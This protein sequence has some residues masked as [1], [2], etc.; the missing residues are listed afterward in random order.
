VA[1]LEADPTIGAASAKVVF[2]ERFAEVE[3]ASPTFVPGTADHRQLGVMV[4]GA[5]VDG[6]DRWRDT[7][8]GAGSWGI[9]HDRSG[10]T[11][12]WTQARAVVRVPVPDGASRPDEVQLRLAAEAPKSVT[13]G[14]GSDAVTVAVGTDP[15]WLTV[16]V[17]GE[18]R[19]VVNN[20]GSVVFDDGYGADRGYLE[21]DEGQFDEGADV[22]AWCGAS[23]LF[24]PVYLEDAGLFDE[25]F[26]LYYED[27]D[28][29]WRGLARGWRHR[30]VPEAVVR[31]VHAAS[32]GEG[33][34][35]FQHFVERNRLLMLTK[36]APAPLARQALVRFVLVT[37]SYARRDVVRP[38]LGGHRP[39]VTQVRRRVG[40]F[41]GWARLAPAM[42]ADRRRLRRR[43]VLSDAE[44]TA[45]MTPR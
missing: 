21:P 12:Q 27:T 19:D 32:T 22:F 44:I 20:V 6:K 14:S 8:F 42:L 11:F 43:Q 37:A 40:S 33:T 31:H 1:T 10:G 28:M 15:V 4:S 45:R 30:Y 13:V 5:R 26:F 9:E 18:P 29:A 16:P 36:D 2:A 34:P 3:I 38:L 39:N 7:Q 24:R 23:V 17:T 35:I 41:L 25:R